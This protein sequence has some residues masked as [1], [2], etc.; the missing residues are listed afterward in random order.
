[1]TRQEANKKILEL[2]SAQVEANPDLR[3]NQILINLK[4]DKRELHYIGNYWEGGDESFNTLDYYEEPMVTLQRM[5][6]N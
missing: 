5:T 6:G 1:M 3:F 2:I 4:V